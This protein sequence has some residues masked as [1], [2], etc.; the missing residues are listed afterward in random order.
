MAAGA[1]GHALGVEI[2]APQLS[3]NFER[4]KEPLEV[5]ARASQLRLRQILLRGPWW[6]QDSGPMVV[7]TQA[8]HLPMALLPVR[9]NRYELFDPVSLA[10]SPVTESVANA[11]DPRAFV[12]YPPLPAGNLN[13]LTLLKFAFQGRQK[14]LWMILLTGV[15][16]SL[17]GMTI[18]QATA[19]LIDDAI[20]Y[21]SENTLIELGLLL[22]AVAFG[23]SCFQFAQAI[24]S[25]SSKQA[26]SP[27]RVALMNSPSKMVYLRG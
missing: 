20:P 6:T 27:S 24:A 26:E 18:P 1:V 2:S 11:L 16:I 7:Y 25:T 10:R 9:D 12:F 8:D 22:L 21:G 14:D 4:V 15:A 17:L 5:I 13:A 3:E 23:R 19:V